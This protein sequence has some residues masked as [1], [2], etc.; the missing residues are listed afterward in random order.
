[1]SSH[2][3]HGPGPAAPYPTPPPW[4]DPDAGPPALL[5]PPG[6]RPCRSPA[7]VAAVRAALGLP[8]AGPPPPAPT[9]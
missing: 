9:P 1:M 4:V 2:Q 7:V 6:P 8:P 5:L 3:P